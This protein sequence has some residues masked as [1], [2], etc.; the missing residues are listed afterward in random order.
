MAAR[1]PQVKYWEFYNEPDN[2][3][4]AFGDKGKQYAAMLNAVYP[5][6]KAA[7]PAAQ[8]VLGGIALDWF[9]S[10]VYDQNFLADVSARYGI[11]LVGGTVPMA[12]RDP[13]KVER[14]A[15]LK[16]PQVLPRLVEEVAE[17]AL[18]G[19]VVAG[20]VVDVLAGARSPESLDQPFTAA[21]SSCRSTYS[22]R[23]AVTC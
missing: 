18:T 10:G 21:F 4:S 17:L 5:S 1:Y 19:D 9:S 12:A 2:I 3:F 11:W 20:R 14:F 23:V 6:V 7:N 8:V 15:R 13:A 16:I 22:V